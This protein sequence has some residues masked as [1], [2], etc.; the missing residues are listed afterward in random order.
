MSNEEVK[1]LAFQ[2]GK[3][4]GEY[5]THLMDLDYKSLFSFLGESNMR[6]KKPWDQGFDLDRYFD[7]S[8]GRDSCE[9]LDERGVRELHA[10]MLGR[11]RELELGFGRL[12]DYLL[13]EQKSAQ[14]TADFRRTDPRSNF[15]ISPRSAAEY[16]AKAY[17]KVLEFMEA[18]VK[19]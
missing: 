17:G 14:D 8:C 2:E 5:L 13:R 4:I 9:G 12:R 1:T 18:K 19:D 10:T 7:D 6:E 11:I 15:T 16:E 3:I